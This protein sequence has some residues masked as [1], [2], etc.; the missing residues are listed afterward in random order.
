MHMAQFPGPQYTCPSCRAAVTRKPVED[1][2]VK[3]LVLWLGSVQG[4]K[5]PESGIPAGTGGT[6]FDGYALL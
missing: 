5:P 3:S 4:L 2:K 1:F 6:M